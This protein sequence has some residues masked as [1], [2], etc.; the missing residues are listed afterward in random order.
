[1]QKMI[2][3]KRL[4]IQVLFLVGLISNTSYCEHKTIGLTSAQAD[5]ARS[6][7]RIVF[8]QANPPNLERMVKEFTPTYTAPYS[9]LTQE[10]PA[11]RLRLLGTDLEQD[12][13]LLSDE[14]PVLDSSL[15]ATIT[16]YWMAEAEVTQK[17]P[18]ELKLSTHDG[19]IFR[20]VEVKAGPNAEVWHVGSVY[21]QKYE[22][23][24]SAVATVFSGDSLLT[25]S[26]FPYQDADIAAVPLQSLP[27]YLTPYVR[28]AQ[29]SDRNLNAAVGKDLRSLSVSFRLGRNARHKITVDDQALGATSA[30]AVV[31]GFSYGSIPQDEPVCDIVVRFHGGDSETWTMLSGVHTARSD[32][33]FYPPNAANHKKVQIVESWQSEYA[34]TFDRPFQ[35]HKYLA[36]FS[37]PQ[38]SGKV[39]SIEFVSKISNVID[40]F[41]VALVREK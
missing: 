27:I 21:V 32:F 29:V 37:V 19:Q 14:R 38:S 3:N 22:L 5:Y 34:D 24:V 12:G 16:C 1:M 25:L 35:K 7:S 17:T 15:P 39:A 9:G 11:V 20:S 41:G 18:L 23:Q 33:D 31:S 13:K 2:N 40:I 28:A 36:L 6:S 8:A 10:L 4:P 30:I 26:L